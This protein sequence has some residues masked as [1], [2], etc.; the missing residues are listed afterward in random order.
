M[1]KGRKAATI[2]ANP[3]W[4][5]YGPQRARFNSP[6]N[7]DKATWQLSRFMGGT[8]IRITSQQHDNRKKRV[9]QLLRYKHCKHV[10][11]VAMQS[12]HKDSL[13]SIR[14]LRLERASLAKL[15]Q[16]IMREQSGFLDRVQAGSKTCHLSKVYLLAL[17]SVWPAFGGNFVY[18]LSCN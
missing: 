3:T 14:Q 18:V 11:V 1:T 17:I 12:P 6:E 9:Q 13:E 8:R 2:T 16:E 5:C 10:V 15:P 4:T 7:P